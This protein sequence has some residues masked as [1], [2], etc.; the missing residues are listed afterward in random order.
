MLLNERKKVCFIIFLFLTFYCYLL[1]LCKVI[2]ISI[3][4]GVELTHELI[5]KLLANEN[6]SKGRE[7]KYKSKAQ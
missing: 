2:A 5:A 1:N 4:K 7:K 6:V 3:K